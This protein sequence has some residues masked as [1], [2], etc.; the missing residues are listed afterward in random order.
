MELL[1]EA[2]AKQHRDR[3]DVH[4]EVGQAVRGRGAVVEGGED[5][6]RLMLPWKPSMP[7][8]YGCTHPVPGGRHTVLDASRTL[9]RRYH[10]DRIEGM[11]SLCS[12]DDE[13]GTLGCCAIE[14]HLLA[15]RGRASMSRTTKTAPSPG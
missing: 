1:P 7:W 2:E 4:A 9:L 13:H 5:T 14:A 11:C 10:T 8:E 15:H 3:E 6:H 12:A